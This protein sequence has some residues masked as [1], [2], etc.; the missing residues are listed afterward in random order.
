MP[1]T[2]TKAASNHAQKEHQKR[3]P[4]GRFAGKAKP[5]AST[6]RDHPQG[7]ALR[8]PR[9]RGR[10][11]GRPPRTLHAGPRRSAHSGRTLPLNTDSSVPTAMVT[12]DQA[13]PILSTNARYGLRRDRA[14]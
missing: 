10:P 2:T 11:R 3:R 13:P 12:S 14:P 4:R 1:A 8:R 6:L 7:G 5:R 9:K